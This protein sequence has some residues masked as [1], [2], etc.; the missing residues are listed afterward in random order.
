MPRLLPLDPDYLGFRGSLCH[1]RMREGA[2]D[3]S[4]VRMIRDLIPRA[5]EGGIFATSRR[6]IGA[7]GLGRGYVAASEQFVETDLIFVHDLV[8]PAQSAPMI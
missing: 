4:S 5:A 7:L 8:L 3:P 6:W 1:G 2:I